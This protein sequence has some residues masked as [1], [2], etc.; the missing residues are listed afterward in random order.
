MFVT[1][2]DGVLASYVRGHSSLCVLAPACGEAVALEHNGDLY[3][4]D[5]FVEPRYLLGNIGQ[6][7]LAELVA[8]AKQRSFGRAKSDALPRYCRECPSL[9]TC[10]GECPKNRIL[11]APDGEPGLNWLC[12]GLKTFF[13]HVDRPM[14]IMADLLRRGRY[15][16]GVMKILAEE[17]GRAVPGEAK[18]GRN[19][20]CPC[21]SGLKFKKCHGR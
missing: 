9:F 7:P 20:P 3:S 11:A 8:S 12:A 14:K 15:A 1:F 16:D 18:I 10:H 6:T 21:G 19:D 17:E 5:H 13:A 2:F 4:C